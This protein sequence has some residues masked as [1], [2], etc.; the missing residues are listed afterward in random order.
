MKFTAGS[1]VRARGREWVVLP[2]SADDFLVLRP[3][4]GT[5]DE[6]AG[7]H[8]PLEPVEPADFPLPDPDRLGDWRSGRLLR[9]AVR[10]GFRNSAGPF[11]CL[12]RLAVT[13]RPYQ[14]VPL[15]MALKLDPVR[16]LIA[17]DVG[18]GKTI[19]AALIARELMDRGEIRRL[20]VLCPPQLVEQ[21]QSELASKFHIE[22]VAVL[23]STVTRLERE[24]PLG[25]SVF[26][27]FPHVVVSMDFIKADRRRDDFLRACPEMVIVDE[28]HTCASG[29]AARGA[30]HQRHLLLKGV[31]ADPKRHLVLVTG[32]P[33]SG[34]EGAFRSL[35]ASLSPDLASLPED[36][37]GEAHRKDREHLARYLVQRRRGDIRHYLKADTPFPRRLEREEPYT[38]S[39]EYRRL[40]DRVLAY[41]REAVP[42]PRDREH[43]VRVRWWSVLA[44]LRALASSPAAAAATLRS[45]AAVADT[46][47]SEAAD[48]VGRLT[49]LDQEEDEAAER[50]DVCP[51]ADP[52][53]HAS[54][55]ESN[56]RRLLDMAREAQSLAGPYDRKVGHGIRVVQGLVRDG[57]SPIVF[58]RFIATAE[59]VAQA[60][61]EA[62][63]H[64]I[65]VACVTGQLPPEEREARV[66]A[67][68]SSPKRVLVATDCLSEGLN[69]Q[70]SFDAVVH[71]DL[72]WNP[73]RHEQREGRV[74]RFGQPR[75][76]VR[77][78]T[79][80]GKDNQIDGIVLEVLLRKHKSIRS[81]TGVSVAVP[82]GTETVLEA[83]FE[84]LL[85]R[86]R[87]GTL[88]DQLNLF[89]DL[90][91][92]TTRK[93]LADWEEASDREQ[94]S[95]SLFAQET[96]RVEEVE[97]EVEAAR[98]ALGSARE[99]E[100][101]TLDALRLHG[102]TVE[103]RNH[104]FLL[105][106]RPLPRGLK[107]AL[108]ASDERMRVRFDLPVA[109][110]TRYLGR[111]DPLVE[112]LAGYVLDS[113]LDP[114]GDGQAARAGVVCTSGVSCRTTV[115]LVR[116]RFHIQQ[117][118]PDQTPPLLAEECRI[119]AFEGPPEDPRWLDESRAEALLSLEPTSNLPL[120]VQKDFVRRVVDGYA[121][122]APAIEEAAR[123]RALR[124]LEAHRRVRQEAGIRIRGLQ[125]EPRLPPDVI[126]LYVYLPAGV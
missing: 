46:D 39:E 34:D 40:F 103:R 22:A 52:G 63:P 49:V 8:V 59:Y 35:L 56:R 48:E 60:L 90:L 97:R 57:F 118:P 84:G 80:Y 36:L 37:T 23:P 70:E 13:P 89:E 110:G 66:Q 92:P 32:T 12:A 53:E 125:V 75:D 72:S 108:R 4:G 43:R 9:E 67:L 88:G 71:Y 28:A 51:G 83:I 65:E 62:L 87:T 81:R 18:I 78:V 111:T 107:D 11:R 2:E 86:E 106:L 14:F 30:R 74:D 68:A 27:T 21:W 29:A 16:L 82:T 58:C 31:A 91:T 95:R 3:L 10:L 76:E 116:F 124:L 50:L 7:V 20:A 101:F 26:D 112:A 77:V 120:S 113:A 119:L 45:R 100:Q 41:A 96:I 93:V 85:L 102:A 47:T 1:L 104:E 121:H 55:P 17:D 69:L 99:V 79:L 15:L 33:H 98:E 38:L 42:D 105:D 6:V 123:T 19:E 61:R 109:A 126:G 122:L 24:C 54:N 5:D 25:R 114:L 73:T 115:L 117:G 64:N 94:R 44:L